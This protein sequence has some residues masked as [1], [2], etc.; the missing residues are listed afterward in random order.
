MGRMTMFM[1]VVLVSLLSG[2]CAVVTGGDAMPDT[3]AVE[4]RPEA[5]S[6]ERAC[7]EEIRP[8]VEE[9]KIGK[10]PRGDAARIRKFAQDQLLECMRSY[11]FEW[12]DNG[13][14]STR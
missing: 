11:G 7:K 4:T 13:W 12:R 1:A 10:C 5:K 3:F 2:G 14:V 9:F 8:R 6:T